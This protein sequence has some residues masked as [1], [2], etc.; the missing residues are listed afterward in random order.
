MRKSES[1]NIN[2]MEYN[3]TEE[4]KQSL[5]EMIVL[6]NSVLIIDVMNYLHRYAWVYR[7]M[8]VSTHR[9][10][11]IFTG[12][13]YGFLHLLAYLRNLYP[14]CS[15]VLALDGIDKE[16]RKINKDY[17]A[18]RGYTVDMKKDN[19][20][21]IESIQNNEVELDYMA[22][23]LID[24]CSLMDGVYTVYDKDYEADDC[25]QCVSN[26]IKTICNSKHIQKRIYILS[27]D[28]DMYQ[29]IDDR[30]NQLCTVNVIKAFSHKTADI[31]YSK[32]VAETFN[33]VY[34]KDVVKFRAIV[35]DM[36]DNLKGYAR[37]RKSIAG[38][39][40]RN[41]DY[42]RKTER[43]SIKSTDLISESDRVELAKA[44]IQKAI[45][46]VTD[47]MQ[48]FVD[49]YNI[50]KMKSF[51]FHIIP[52]YKEIYHKDYKDIC[53][54]LKAYKLNYYIMSLKRDSYYSYNA[55]R[56]R[57]YL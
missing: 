20:D 1:Y 35:G 36:S 7:K 12:P 33:Q 6:N 9:Y 23:D 24:F 14:K 47:N 49:N 45:A 46:K 37:F 38:L 42:D 28:K 15:I 53:S 55:D 17:K 29:L 27:N 30:P 39:I 13:L 26:V 50:M 51:D 10:G 4:T 18:N 11:V 2:T 41:Y 3:F 48:I 8:R 56:F 21:L 34:P 57:Q 31:V 43:L 44:N 22:K 5:Y 25:I 54:R 32:D 52:V 19:K 16:R 40:A